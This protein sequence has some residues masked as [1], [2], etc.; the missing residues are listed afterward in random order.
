MK[1]EII[2]R[3]LEFH[4]GVNFAWPYLMLPILSLLY[5]LYVSYITGMYL[6]LNY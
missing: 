4:V 5:T 6:N 2:T 3:F 1:D